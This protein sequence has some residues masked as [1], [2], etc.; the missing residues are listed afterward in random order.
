[1][2]INVL[3]ML[4]IEQS[5]PELKEWAEVFIRNGE[6]FPARLDLWCFTDRIATI[7]MPPTTP[8]TLEG[9]WSRLT[10]A[11]SLMGAT[12]VLFAHRAEIGISTTLTA[13]D[14][15][16]ACLCV[17]LSS[18]VNVSSAVWPYEYSAEANLVTWGSDAD[19]DNPIK[20]ESFLRTFLTLSSD[21]STGSLD[22]FAYV[23]WLRANGY[24][25]EFHEPFNETNFAYT[26]RGL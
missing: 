6:V 13:E 5:E 18:I 22:P 26:A 4:A 14:A 8:E 10:F 7:V 19:S 12:H 1:M 21:A 11:T 16:T 20:N 2:P 15:K 25:V 9:I 17:Y 23:A 3:K 24:S